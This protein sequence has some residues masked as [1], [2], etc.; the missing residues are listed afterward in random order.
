MIDSNLVGRRFVH[1]L[2]KNYSK[3]ILLLIDA[4]CEQSYGNF[5]MKICIANKNKIGLFMGEELIILKR[6]K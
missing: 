3:T 6:Q 5:T 2:D 1:Y 4:N